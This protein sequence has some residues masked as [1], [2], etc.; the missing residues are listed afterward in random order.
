MGLVRLRDD[1]D[2]ELTVGGPDAKEPRSS[3][4][5]HIQQART[6]DGASSK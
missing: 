4:E 3:S 6:D 2:D 1:G 5:L